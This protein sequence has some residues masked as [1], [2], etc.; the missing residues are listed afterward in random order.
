M[1]TIFPLILIVILVSGCVS[2]ETFRGTTITGNEIVFAS[3]RDSKGNELYLM[4]DDGTNIRQLT[5]NDFEDNNPAFSFDKKKVAF[6]RATNPADFTS[7]EI[8]VID[9]E[10]GEET[11]ITNNNQLDGHPDWSPDGKKIVF[12]RFNVSYADLFIID[13]ESGEETQLMN[14]PLID[15]ND[16]E[17]SPDGA[18]IAFKSTQVTNESGREEIYVMDA[19]GSNTRRLTSTEGWQSDHDPSWS[20]DSKYVYFERFEGIVPWYEIQNTYY[21][22]VNFENLIPWNIYRVDLKGEEEQITNCN[23]ICWL[24][25]QYRDR[26]MFFSDEFGIINETL[27]SVKVDYKTIMP[28]G[29]GEEFLFN[30]DEFAYKK[31]YFDF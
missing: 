13:L 30:D 3:D 16:P 21:F 9:L 23:Y 8:Y 15:E 25:V 31:A 12:A 6:H 27:I 22:L 19:D 29:S 20:S 4:N 17:W 7:Y 26:I 5:F 2:S 28:D 11:R 24:P 10:T 14:T 18:M 1:K